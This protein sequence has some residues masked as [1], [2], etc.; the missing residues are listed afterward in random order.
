MSMFLLAVPMTA[1]FA[2]AA[3]IAVLH[4][5]AAARRLAIRADSPESVTA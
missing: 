1:L 5:R 3:A 4:D 2:V